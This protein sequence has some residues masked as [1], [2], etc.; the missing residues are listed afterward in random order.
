MKKMKK[1]ILLVSA[2]GIFLPWNESLQ[3]S[4]ASESHEDHL[5]ITSLILPC[6]L[7]NSLEDIQSLCHALDVKSIIK[8]LKKFQE[9][10]PRYKIYKLEK[11]FFDALKSI[12]QRHHVRHNRTIQ[13]FLERITEEIQE[14]QEFIAPEHRYLLFKNVMPWHDYPIRMSIESGDIDQLK[15]ALN[16]CLIQDDI[17]NDFLHYEK[18]ILWQTYGLW[19]AHIKEAKDQGLWDE[20]L[21][22]IWE[23]ITEVY[24]LK[25]RI[26]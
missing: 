1:N 4:Q 5:E 21:D 22:D 10:L 24:H 6:C 7:Q 20:E 9:A 11:N 8:F 14:V 2:M 18:Y 16:D 19:E 3:G 25:S 23:H 13:S 15:K 26:L 17:H 12:I